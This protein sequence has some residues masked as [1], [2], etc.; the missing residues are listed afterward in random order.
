MFLDV[1]SKYLG[2]FGSLHRNQNTRMGASPYKPILLLAVLDES[3]GGPPHET[4]N[5]VYCRC[6]GG[7]KPR[8]MLFAGMPAS[9]SSFTTSRFVPSCST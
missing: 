8:T 6:W 9:S 2:I 5:S 3:A 1:L 4:A 7:W